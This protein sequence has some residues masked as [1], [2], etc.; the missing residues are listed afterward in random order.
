MDGLVS[1][2]EQYLLISC[3]RPL[4]PSVLDNSL[5]GVRSQL[6][7]FGIAFQDLAFAEFGGNFVCRDVYQATEDLDAIAVLAKVSAEF[8]LALCRNGG[9]GDFDVIDVAVRGLEAYRAIFS[10]LFWRAMLGKEMKG[11]IS[12]LERHAVQ[13]VAFGVQCQLME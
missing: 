11:G 6:L 3:F 4:I 8:A 12:L 9:I 13:L 5:L 2:R 10:A 7:T 1:F